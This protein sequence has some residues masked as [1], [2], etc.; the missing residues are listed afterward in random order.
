MRTLV[1]GSTG[2]TGRAL[3]SSL[4]AKDDEVVRLV[5]SK[6][7]REYEVYWDP[8][9]GEIDRAGLEGLHRVVHLAGENIAAG[10]W[11]EQQKA[12]IRDSRVKGT[13]LLSEALAGLG[14][15]PAVMVCASAVGFYGD[16]GDEVMTEDSSPGSGFLAEVCRDWEAATEA[17]SRSGIRL[18][19]LRIGMVLSFPGGA[20]E[21]MLP[22][23]KMG[24]GGK[25]G[26]GE[27][28]MSWIELS[29]LVAVISHALSDSSLTGPVN[30]V[31]PG[32]VTNLE[33]TKTLGRVL[34]RPTVFP[35]PAF[36][37]RLAFGEMADELILASTRAKPA[38]LLSSGFSFRFS[39][40][41][42]ALRVLLKKT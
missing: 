33:F 32:A 37:A 18:T 25:I 42:D 31:S 17:A 5:R 20:L 26:S 21:K 1:T 13:R 9:R 6:P 8:A 15:P 34:G 27:Q 41:E 11:T 4:I 29:D 30:A 2:L 24:L 22:P 35:M 28:Y 38:K 39:D 40:L 3:V 19:N 12:R 14:S 16:R 36:A 10:R 7:L 23:F